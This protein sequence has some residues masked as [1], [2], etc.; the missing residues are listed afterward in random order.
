MANREGIR[1]VKPVDPPVTMAHPLPGSLEVVRTADLRRGAP[2]WRDLVLR[3]KASSDYQR[4]HPRVAVE[5]IVGDLA[6]AE[7]SHDRDI[8]KGLL[9][10]LELMGVV[11][12]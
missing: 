2:A 11:P 9:N 6:I 1:P 8:A 7:E 5:A 12:K 3:P 10:R 4:Q